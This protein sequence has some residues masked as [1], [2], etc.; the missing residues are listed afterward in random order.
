MTSLCWQKTRP[1]ALVVLGFA[2]TLAALAAAHAAAPPREKITL[3]V[4][5][6]AI[7]YAPIYFGRT[8][9]FFAEQGLELEVSVLRTDLALTGLMSGKLDYIAHGGAALRGATQGIPI[10]LVYAL[11]DKSVFWL[12]T[13]PGIRSTAMLKGK[14]I[15][16]SFPGDTPHLVLKRFLK[17]AGLDPDRDVTYVAGQ[18][19]PI[20]FQGLSAGALDAAVMAPP[21]TVIAQDKG[22][23]GLA[24]LGKE[25]PDA[26]TINGIVTSDAKIRSQPDQVARI[27]AAMLKS[28]QHYR[29]RPDAAVA[30]LSTQFNLEPGV[31]SRIYRDSLATLIAN[32]EVGPD[33]VRDALNLARESGQPHPATM[34]PESLLDMSFLRQAQRSSVKPG[35]AAIK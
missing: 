12:I 4:P 8:E 32:G 13:Q 27:V 28:V 3:A 15:G 30:L 23:R 20:G 18:I 7:Q 16:I 17:N 35:P 26:P 33:K 1:S 5:V 25:V 11:D 10:K 9:G 34:D 14:S 24:F 19:S 31:A 21:Y 29:Q 22:F 2:L 6:V